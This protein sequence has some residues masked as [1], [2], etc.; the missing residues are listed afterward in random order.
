[1]SEVFSETQGRGLG[2]FTSYEMLRRVY[3]DMRPRLEAASIP[4]FAQGQDGTREALLEQFS[5]D[6]ASVLL[7]TTS[8]WEGVDVKGEALSAL[9]VAKLPFGVPTD[10]IIKG[11]CDLMEAAGQNAFMEYSLPVA[12]L[13]L[14]QGFGRLIRAQTD[15]G[16]VVVADKRVLTRRYGGA[17]LRSLPTGHQVASSRQELRQMVRSFMNG[18]Q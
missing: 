9:V 15:R 4:V 10:P 16:V 8:F 13:R 12:V 5:R 18:G 14:R 11:R 1:M 6:V 2:L 3:E 7:G 17:F